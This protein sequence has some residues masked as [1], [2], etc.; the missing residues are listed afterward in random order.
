M[1]EIVNEIKQIEKDIEEARLKW[2]EKKAL[3]HKEMER[4]I[5]IVNYEKLNIQEVTEYI[6]L[7]SVVL[8]FQDKTSGIRIN[9]DDVY[10]EMTKAPNKHFLMKGA[11]LYFSQRFN[12]SIGN[13]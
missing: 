5:R 9:P 6:N 1:K 4:V 8:A 7:E 3:I 13:T 12:G 2:K 10:N 11:K